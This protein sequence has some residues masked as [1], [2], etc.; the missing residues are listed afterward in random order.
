MSSELEPKINTNVEAELSFIASNTN[1][2]DLKINPPKRWFNICVA[3][4]IGVIGTS[5][6]ATIGL[7]IN[8]FATK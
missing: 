1:Y 8:Y 3:L 7:I 6:G 4:L 5:I 2:E